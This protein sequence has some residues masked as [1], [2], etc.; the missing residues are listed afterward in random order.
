MFDDVFW[1][2]DPFMDPS[3][4]LKAYI[5]WHIHYPTGYNCDVSV[6]ACSIIRKENIQLD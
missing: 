5:S 1:F 4:Q 3:K 2:M 6:D